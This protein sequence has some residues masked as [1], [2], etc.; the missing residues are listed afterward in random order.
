LSGIILS[1]FSASPA[2]SFGRLASFIALVACLVWDTLYLFWSKKLPDPTQYLAQ[3]GFILA[4]YG[5]SKA[6]ETIQ[7]LGSGSPSSPS[8][9]S[10]PATKE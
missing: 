10:P 6:G 9:S 8:S 2:L 3:T 1:L 4:L 7:K 5:V